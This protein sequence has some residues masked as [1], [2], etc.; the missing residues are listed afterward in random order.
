MK[1]RSAR[2]TSRDRLIRVALGAALSLA[3]FAPRA[4]LPAPQQSILPRDAAARPFL[5]GRELVEKGRFREAIPKLESAL[6]TGHQTPQL[7]FGASRHQVDYYDPHYWLG[8]ALMELGEEE[9]AL[10]HLRASAAGGSFPDRRETEDRRLRIVELE[11]REAARRAPPPRTPT[12]TPPPAPTPL[13]PAPTPAPTVSA[14]LETPELVPT[15]PAEPPATPLLLV[16]T[17]VPPRLEGPLA[18]LAAGDFETTVERVRAERKRTPDARELDLVEA[19][20][21]GGRFVL[22]GR[23][24][25]SLLDRARESLAAFRSKGGS[26]RAEATLLS[27]ALRTLLE[28]R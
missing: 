4:G 25:R 23:R 7:R 24:D 14:A 20:A 19:A 5:E 9:R 12:P 27:P 17:P 2:S 22:E 6:S 28:T 8:R 3:A 15:P 21:L 16:P 11:R 13:P 1:C 10:S 26:A 18:A